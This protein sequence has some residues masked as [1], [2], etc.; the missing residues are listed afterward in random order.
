MGILIGEAAGNLGENL[1]RVGFEIR[2]GVQWGRTEIGK[3]AH[4]CPSRGKMLQ[5][6][7]TAT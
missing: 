5:S 4:H 6:V 2:L 1:H 3:F 7:G